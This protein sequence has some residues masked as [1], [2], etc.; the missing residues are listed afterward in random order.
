MKVV[1][2]PSALLGVLL[3]LTSIVTL[4]VVRL[5]PVTAGEVPTIARR[6]E[7]ESR[8][9]QVYK[10]TNDAVVFITTITLSAD[11]MDVFGIESPRQGTGSGVIV[12]AQKGIVITNLHVI[13]GANKVE[14]SLSDGHNYHAKLLGYDDETDIAALQILNPPRNL[15]SIPFGD[16]SR[17]EVGQRVVAIGNPFGLNR[18][19]TTG[20]VS[21]VERTVRTGNNILLRGL[22]QTDAAINP[23]NS[24][25]PLLDTEGRLIGINTAILS[26]SGESAGIGFAMPINQ[27]KRILKDLVEKGRV[28]RPSMGWIL[29]DTDQGPMVLRVLA[30]GP[31]AEADVAPIERMVHGFMRRYIRDVANGDLIVKVNGKRVNTRDDVEE[32]ISNNPAD[33]PIKLTLRRGGI[34]GNEREVTVKPVLK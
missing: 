33:R 5:A 22:V 3:T 10:A 8:I 20:V 21:S 9:I 11:P 23:G 15:T 19:L 26:A 13:R 7:E 18:T 1:R 30:T 34:E 31:A 14:V 12:D 27:I 4:L 25:G 24:G 16:S 6:S 32:I 28:L 2:I 17:L 29:V